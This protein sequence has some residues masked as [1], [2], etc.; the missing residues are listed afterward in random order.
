MKKLK[1]KQPLTAVHIVEKE[2]LNPYNPIVVNLIGAGG[3]GSQVLTA[4]ARMNHALIELNHP[5]LFVRLFDDDKVERANLG[6]QLFATAELKQYKAVALINRVNLF[7]GTNWKAL[8]TR[9]DKAGLKAQNELAQAG[10]TISCVDTV[11]A[12]LEIADILKAV[13]K[14]TNGYGRNKPVYYMDF[15]NSRFSGQ[16]ILSTIG[17]VPQPEMKKYQTVETLPMVTDEF[18]DLLMA[19]ESADKTPSCSLAEALT[20]QDLFIN[21][22]LANVGASLLWQLFREGVLFNRGFFLNLKEFR[23]Q[24]LKVSA[25]VAKIVPMKPKRTKRKVA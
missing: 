3:T 8:T 4:L 5:G 23:M 7:F 20:K 16:V 6:R 12:R 10:L 18:K 9:Y 22:A 11:Q 21:S 19:S 13:Y 15:G 1:I 17:K 2:W 25:P 24:P 14:R